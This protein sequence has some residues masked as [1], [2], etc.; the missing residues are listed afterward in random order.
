MSYVS[1]VLADSPAF[2]LE[3]NGNANDSS[4][5][6]RHF[7]DSGVTQNQGSMLG[8]GS[9][10][11]AVFSGAAPS[12]LSL[13]NNVWMDGTSVTFSMRYRHVTSA[14][15][16]MYVGR[17]NAGSNR[18]WLFYVTGNKVQCQIN[19]S[20]AV[21]VGATT[22]VGG[23]DYTLAFR[24]DGVTVDLLVNGVVDVSVAH[25]GPTQIGA[26]FEMGRAS[27]SA[28]SPG[29]ASNMA[30]WTSAISTARLLAQ[31]QAALGPNASASLSL[32]GAAGEATVTAGATGSLELEGI[33]G[34]HWV[35]VTDTTNAFR[36]LCVGG[37][38]QVTITQAIVPPPLYAPSPGVEKA[39][40]FGTPTLV[41]GRA[42]YPNLNT[43]SQVAG[44]GRVMVDGKDITWFRAGSYGDQPTQVPGYTS[45][46]PFAYGASEVLVIPR[47]NSFFET[48]GTGELAFLRAGAP[49]LYQTVDADG[50][51]TDY[52]GLILAVRT[53]DDADFPQFQVDVGGEVT[54]R[55][56]LIDRPPTLI[57]G[58]RDLG[59]HVSFLMRGM[60]FQITPRFPVTGLKYPAEGGVT[61]LSWLEKLCALSQTSEVNQRTIMPTV[62][63]GSMWKFEPKDL[64]TIHATLYA[65]GSRISLDL[66]DDAAEKPNTIYGS[67]VSPDGERWRNAMYPGYFQGTPDDYPI[68]GGA[69]FG[70]GTTDADTIDGDGITTLRIKLAWSGLLSD[71]K[72]V[73]STYDADVARAVNQLKD[74]AGLTQDGLMTLAT[75]AAL[76]DLDVVGYSPEGAKVFPLTQAAYVRTYNTSSTGSII[77]IND[78]HIA[79]SLRVDR[80]ID[81]GI[82]EKETA[83]AHAKTITHRDPDAHEWTGSITLEDIAVFAGDTTGI[84]PGDLTAANLMSAH[85]IRPGMNVILPHFDGGT[86]LHVS[87]ANRSGKTVRLDVSTRGLDVF[88]LT[89]ALERN[90]ES[91]RN[92]YREWSE[93]NRG[94]KAPG[95]FVSRDEKFGKVSQNVA[96]VGGA[97]NVVEGI[98]VGQSGTVNYSDLRMSIPTEFCWAVFDKRVAAGTLD[99]LLGNPF[100]LDVDGR[101]VWEH[102]NMDAYFAKRD[103]RIV[104]GQGAQPCGYGWKKGYDSN[105]PEGETRGA[106]TANP[107]TGTDE[108]AASWT[109]GT[110]PIGDPV[111]YLAIYPLENCELKRGRVFSALEDDAT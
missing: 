19:N 3:L 16:R 62:W 97:W 46:E 68:V 59:S 87:G 58:L 51:E 56:S 107:L 41:K 94:V 36:G 20:G 108:D 110:D 4:G 53:G 8:D 93:T 6:A 69:P 100:S 81:Y 31:H 111:F 39:I 14:G 70:I 11:S 1:E 106:R 105:I 71:A 27:L 12:V 29:Q 102:E 95:H 7:T 32:A 34:A 42:T 90:A 73:G 61:A 74:N 82:C 17:W 86:V 99:G 88:D 83:L 30:F 5:N 33:A 47:T 13:A 26:S 24:S 60:G 40:A 91:R 54:G 63:G 57:R 75:W 10:S 80:T 23:Q 98:V 96:L 64:D 109:Y 18:P 9:G 92:I 25:T 43:V 84:D 55:A 104:K 15:T 65:D 48:Y 21:A 45:M 101:T 28:Y 49:V 77:G 76:W 85:R 78:S 38:A 52:R 79:R 2:L 103:L 67:G 72:S 89:Q 66:I 37:I 44:V 22:L 35:N 50:V